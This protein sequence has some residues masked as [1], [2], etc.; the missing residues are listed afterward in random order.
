MKIHYRNYC[1]IPTEVIKK[2]KC[3]HYNKLLLES[4]NKIKTVWR[5]VKLE[6]G[7]YSRAEENK[8]V[9]IYAHTIEHLK[10]KPTAVGFAIS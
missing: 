1:K 10:K 5:T 9:M 2:P 4:D 7:E 3:L 8:P 6:T